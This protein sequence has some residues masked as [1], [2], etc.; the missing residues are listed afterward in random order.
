M[1]GGE[2]SEAKGFCRHSRRGSRRKPPSKAQL[3]VTSL[4]N[5]NPHH[6]QHLYVLYNF[7]PTLLHNVSED[8]VS[9]GTGYVG[10]YL[11]TVDACTASTRGCR[12][13]SPDEAADR[14]QQATDSRNRFFL[15]DSDRLLNRSNL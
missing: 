13:S 7:V 14:R 11:R 4:A 1:E 6:H 8:F 10:M 9:T 2:P 3:E 15:R 5:Q 12:P